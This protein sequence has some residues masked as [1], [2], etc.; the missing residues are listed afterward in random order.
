[1][2]SALQPS[3]LTP[4]LKDAEQMTCD[5]WCWVSEHRLGPHLL[6]KRKLLEGDV[7]RAILKVRVGLRRT[8]LQQT[9]KNTTIS[10]GARVQKRRLLDCT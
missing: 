8:V 2:A 5:A 10:C 3:S 6:L 4:G 9:Q 1:M 7:P